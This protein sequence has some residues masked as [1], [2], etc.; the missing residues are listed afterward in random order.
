[1]M[2]SVSELPDRQ[3]DIHSP[4]EAVEITVAEAGTD[5]WINIDGQCVLRIQGIHVPL[6]FEQYGKG[7]KKSNLN[8][9]TRVKKIREAS[10][11]TS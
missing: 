10:D 5:V 4:R 1:M 8:K 11:L 9:E 2:S 3:W 7:T 6:L